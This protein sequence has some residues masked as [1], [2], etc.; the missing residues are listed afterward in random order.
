LEFAFFGAAFSDVDFLLVAFFGAAFLLVAFFGAAFLL[1]AFFGA[2]F[3]EFAVFGAAFWEFAFF[4]AALLAGV[5]WT[6]TFLVVVVLGE[7]FFVD[8]V[9]VFL[10][11]DG[12]LSM[13]MGSSGTKAS[14][15]LCGQVLTHRR[16]I[17]VD[18]SLADV[19]GLGSGQ[20]AVGHRELRPAVDGLERELQ[21]RRLGS[22]GPLGGAPGANDA[23]VRLERLVLAEDV[24]RR[25]RE[26]PGLDRFALADGPSEGAVGDRV[27]EQMKN[28]RG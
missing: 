6:V 3:L 23:A 16:P 1:V 25:R 12:G 9:C 19:V 7:T 14:S 13:G 11:D 20:L 17:G 4:G 24:A 26:A 15:G 5:F 22:S 2:A 28:R 18:P 21:A 27:G 8:D 10:R